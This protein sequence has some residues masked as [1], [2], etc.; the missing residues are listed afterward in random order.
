MEVENDLLRA[1]LVVSSVQRGKDIA[2]VNQ[3]GKEDFAWLNKFLSQH[4]P[5]G[6][7]FITTLQYQPLQRVCGRYN[8]D[9]EYV[10][11]EC[12]SDFPRA[13]AWLQRYHRW[14]KCTCGQGC[15]RRTPKLIFHFSMEEMMIL[16]KWTKGSFTPNEDAGSEKLDTSEQTGWS[17]WSW[18]QAIVDYWWRPHMYDYLL[19]P[20]HNPASVYS[21]VPTKVLTRKT[22]EIDWGARMNNHYVPKGQIGMVSP[23]PPMDEVVLETI[24][25]WRSKHPLQQCLVI[26]LHAP[27]T[28]LMEDLLES[29]EVGWRTWLREH[30]TLTFL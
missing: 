27:K 9:P 12:L 28:E 11:M 20:S 26:L 25:A 17:A 4:Y 6:V 3:G 8:F 7:Q 13:N 19:D 30:T 14:S 16:M 5:S 23:P 2:L 1:Q 10:V 15:G 21:F 29:G 24:P 22:A 18:I